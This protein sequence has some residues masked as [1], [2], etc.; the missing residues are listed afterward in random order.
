MVILNTDLDN[1]LIYSYKHDIGADKIGVELYDNR[2]IS[3]IT[4]K[5]YELLKALKEEIMIVPASTRTIEQYKRIN[6]GVGEFEYALVCNGGVLL[7]NGEIEE[8]WYEESLKIIRNSVNVLEDARRMLE[9]DSRRKFE[10]RFINELFI[11][12]KCNEPEKVVADLKA[13]L[14]NSLVD[15][16]N[17]GEKV[18]VV[19]AKLSKGAAV[20]RFKRYIKMKNINV[21]MVIAAGDSEFDISMLEMAD[22]ALAPS[23]FAKAYN[24]GFEVKEAGEGELFSEFLLSYCVDAVKRNAIT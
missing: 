3:Y 22:A 10:L 23:G 12:T 24:I 8:A 13:G 9:S 14:G 15:I 7:V 1:T 4:Y 19:P 21:D 11:F 2:E 16:F 20:E 18:Y 5:T 6:L 17:N